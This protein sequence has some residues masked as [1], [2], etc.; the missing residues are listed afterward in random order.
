MFVD[1]LPKLLVGPDDNRVICI[2]PVLAYDRKVY[3]AQ[4]FRILEYRVSPYIQHLPFGTINHICIRCV[5][6]YLSL[7]YQYLLLRHG[8]GQHLLEFY[9]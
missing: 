2:L 1:L 4:V 3:L 5:E 9:H 6:V 8:G 7:D